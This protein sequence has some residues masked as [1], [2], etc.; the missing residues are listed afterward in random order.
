MAGYHGHNA[1]SEYAC[2]DKDAEAMT[3]GSADHNGVLFYSAKTVC[4]SLK[5]P[6]YSANT[7][8][9]CAVCTKWINWQLERGCL[10]CFLEWCPFSFYL[11]DALEFF[12]DPHWA[13]CIGSRWLLSEENLN[14]G[15]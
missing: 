6:P 10:V 12:C 8:V 9:P 15:Q 14:S 4:G 3:G 1:A 13:F 7:D 11:S 2:V 5:C